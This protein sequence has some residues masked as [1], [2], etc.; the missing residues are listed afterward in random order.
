MED[1]VRHARGVVEGVEVDDLAQLAPEQ[2]A[3]VDAVQLVVGHR[4]E[5]IS[6]QG[7][8]APVKQG[9]AQCCVWDVK[10]VGIRSQLVELG[11]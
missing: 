6:T 2:V 7:S 11:V 9:V 8:G 5:D 10:A 3:H 4:S 1:R